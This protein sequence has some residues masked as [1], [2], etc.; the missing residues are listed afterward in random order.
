LAEGAALE[1]NCLSSALL[2]APIG[3]LPATPRRSYAGSGPLIAI[4]DTGPLYAG[5]NAND[6]DHRRCAE[7]LEDNRLE[8]VVP[9]LVVAEACYLIGTRLGPRIEARFLRGLAAI[10]VELPTNDEWDQIAALVDRYA[11]FPLGGA[12]A[13]VAVLAERLGTDVIVTLDRRHFGAIR[14]NDGRAFRLLPE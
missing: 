3:P 4:V 9:A 7:V 5:V 6:Q 10:E 14:M 1:E 8:L 12:D 11:D 2:E 13:S